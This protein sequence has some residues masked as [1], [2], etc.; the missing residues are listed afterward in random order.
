MAG[1]K[2]C[3]AL[4]EK[5][6]LHCQEEKNDRVLK[7]QNVSV[8]GVCPRYCRADMKISLQNRK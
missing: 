4:K 3:V 2:P 5:K 7:E 1:A 8:A 6:K